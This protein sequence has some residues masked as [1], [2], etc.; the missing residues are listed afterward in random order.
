MN[1]E[2][3]DIIYLRESRDRLIK[4]ICN[5]ADDPKDL[6]ALLEDADLKKTEIQQIV[7][8]WVQSQP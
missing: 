2:G 7:Y 5:L 3:E 4:L 1:D 6:V 8:K